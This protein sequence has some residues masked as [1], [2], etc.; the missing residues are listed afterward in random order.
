[1]AR[2]THRTTEILGVSDAE[3]V[4]ACNAVSR[5]SGDRK[6]P[7]LSLP[8]TA[9]AIQEWQRWN[10]RD[11]EWEF[12]SSA[13][14]EEAVDVLRNSW[15]LDTKSQAARLSVLKWIDDGCKNAYTKACMICDDCIISENHAK[16]LTP[17]TPIQ[18]AGRV[19]RVYGVPSTGV[20]HWFVTMVYHCNRDPRSD[21]TSTESIITCPADRVEVIPERQLP[22][23]VAQM[24]V[25]ECWNGASKTSD[26][27]RR[28]GWCK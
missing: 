3:L 6:G 5:L 1:M 14:D 18:Y 9:T 24:T 22:L 12:L 10:D 2:D 11:G 27:C 13:S 17:G 16:L 21:V 20:S 4:E 25:E 23:D 28:L 19:G 8:L 7:I 26:Y 15:D